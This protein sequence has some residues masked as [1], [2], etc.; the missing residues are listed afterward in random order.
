MKKRIYAL[1]IGLTVSLGMGTTLATEMEVRDLGGQNFILGNWANIVEPEEKANS[2]EEA[3]WDFRH[4]MMEDFNFT[5]EISALGLW[6]T[7]FERVHAVNLSC[8][9][10][11]VCVC[12]RD[13]ERMFL[14]LFF[15]SVHVSV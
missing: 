1:A 3:L 5:L 11:C 12:E 14:R 10:L 9:R 13:P 4:D 8:P 6:N 7:L 2:R 15:K